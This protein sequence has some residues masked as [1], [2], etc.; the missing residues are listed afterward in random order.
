MQIAIAIVVG[1]TSSL[2]K[3]LFIWGTATA[4]NWGDSTSQTWG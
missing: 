3:K 4:K 1:K 2:I